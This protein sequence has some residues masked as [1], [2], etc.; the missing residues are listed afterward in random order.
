MFH[1][2]S[3]NYIPRLTVHLSAIFV[4]WLPLSYSN[5]GQFLPTRYLADGL[6]SHSFRRVSFIDGQKAER[7]E[8]MMI[9]AL[10]FAD[11]FVFTAACVWSQ[12]RQHAAG[13][14]NCERWKER[15][16]D[17]ISRHA[18]YVVFRQL[19]LPGFIIIWPLPA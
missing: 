12:P 13:N 10:S 4:R 7:Q 5:V 1:S 9:F 16:P 6:I 8:E 19:P 14:L 17:A 11:D 3:G 2:F 15:D 18:Y